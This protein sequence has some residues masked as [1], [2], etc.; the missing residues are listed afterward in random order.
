MI[1]IVAG[2][3]TP[4]YQT[5][6]QER[7]PSELRGRVFASTAAA[8][9]LAIPPAV[10]LA[11]YVVEAFGLRAALVVF[12]GGNA[13]YGLLKLMLPGAEE[14]APRYGGAGARFRRH[15]LPRRPIGRRRSTVD[16][17]RHRA[18]S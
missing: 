6:R 16:R 11:G 5:V 1:G 17:A 9:S 10:L 12:A 4:L 13:F 15:P 2:A 18:L 7:T 8:E 3:G 14:I